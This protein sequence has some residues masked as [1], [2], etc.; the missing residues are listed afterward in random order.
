MQKERIAM[1][2]VDGVKVQGRLLWLAQHERES[3]KTHLGPKAGLSKGWFAA[4][5]FAV[6]RGRRVSPKT[7]TLLSCVLGCGVNDILAD[8]E[9]HAMPNA[10]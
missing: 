10:K 1:Y 3:R 7:L 9:L 5:M 2:H 4:T 6:N 8:C